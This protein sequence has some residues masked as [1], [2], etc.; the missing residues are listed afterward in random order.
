M[1]LV[2]TL[3]YYSKQRDYDGFLTAELQPDVPIAFVHIRGQ[4]E[5][6][7]THC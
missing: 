7:S 3:L 4:R 2:L 5:T 6:L 1:I